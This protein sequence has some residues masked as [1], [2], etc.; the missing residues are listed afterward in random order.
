MVSLNELRAR[1]LEFTIEF[2]DTPLP[3][4]AVQDNL[5]RVQTF[6]SDTYIPFLK[7]GVLNLIRE[8]CSIN[9]CSLVDLFFEEHKNILGNLLTEHNRVKEYTKA[10]L[11]IPPEKIEVGEE[12]TFVIVN[13]FEIRVKYIKREIVCVPIGESLK[14]ILETPGVFD[15]I[16]EYDKELKQNPYP[17]SNIKQ[18]DLWQKK[19]AKFEEDIILFPFELF[20]DAFEA[21]DGMGSAAGSQ[22]LTGVYGSLPFLP[23]HLAHRNDMIVLI[24]LFYTKYQALFGNAALFSHIIKQLNDLR[25][26]GLD[27]RV[28]TRKIT[29]HF[30]LTKL[31]GDNLAL[32]ER[33]GLPC[34]FIA[35][36]FCRMCLAT[37]SMCKCMCIAD[38][39]L[40]R[41]RENYDEHAKNPSPANGLTEVCVFNQVVGHHIAENKSADLMHDVSGGIIPYDLS[42]ILTALVLGDDEGNRP[43][44][45]LDRINKA[46]KEF[47]FGPE[48]NRP[49]PLRF[50][51]RNKSKASKGNTKRKRKI[52]IRQSASEA[53]CLCRYL[54]LIIGHQIPR[55]NKHW[56][57]YLIVRQ[58]IDI[59]TA[60]SHMRSHVAV[61]RSLIEKH[62]SMYIELY[63]PLKPKMHIWLHYIELMLLNGPMINSWSM[64]FERKNK[65]LRAIATACN[66]SINL[67]LS[68]CKR[69]Q[70]SFCNIGKKISGMM[71]IFKLGLILDPADQELRTFQN[72]SHHFSV[73]TYRSITLYNKNY[74]QGSIIF[75]GSNDEEGP[76][77][78][79]LHK[80]Y[81]INGNIYF[82]LQ[83]LEVIT[84]D[85]HYHA[86]E[87]V[88]TKRCSDFVEVSKLPRQIQCVMA[89]IDGTHYVAARHQF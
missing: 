50:E 71:P 82:L 55:G 54:G 53:L 24:A 79:S 22:K 85:S 88:E 1:I 48:Q 72:L 63:G 74:S 26:H 3:R 36:R 60:P 44:I 80:I 42:E 58:I 7:H 87:V 77:L 4:S 86:Y 64:P 21:G 40:A 38:P 57:L 2:Y 33:C 14:K 13:R 89:K 84:F 81:K 43:V 76:K 62:N 15:A 23:P 75:L 73:P 39:N 30:Q 18:G 5:I 25:I 65:T 49:R 61:L 29:V 8:N 17:I 37:S 78:R 66:S 31:I 68:I 52:K 59:V 45:T 47:N 41:N 11:Y 16:L 19:Y 10:N 6:I 51:Y 20:D 35:L 32:N 69:H 56:A 46:I 67:P 34:S 28:G 83:E 12:R 27:I 70:L 9:V